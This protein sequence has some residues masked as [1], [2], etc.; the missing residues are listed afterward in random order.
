[1]L[2]KLAHG[3]AAV[4]TDFSCKSGG[5]TRHINI[6]AF[7]TDSYN[8]MQVLR[9]FSN[10]LTCCSNDSFGTNNPNTRPNTNDLISKAY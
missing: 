6:H 10:I 8:V 7:V 3:I 4:N 9:T 5:K 1:M 2:M